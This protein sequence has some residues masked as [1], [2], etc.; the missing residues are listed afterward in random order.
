MNIAQADVATIILSTGLM[1]GRN[2]V[3][4]GDRKKEGGKEKKRVDIRVMTSD[5]TLKV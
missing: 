5:F 3:K 1:D 4:E 2:E